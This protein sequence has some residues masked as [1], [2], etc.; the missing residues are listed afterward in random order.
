MKYLLDTNTRTRYLRDPNSRVRREL[1]TRPVADIFL[2]SVVLAELYRG[3]HKS[4]N[5]TANRATVDA[6]VAPY[7]SLS[8][9]D[10]AA[11]RQAEVRVSLERLGLMIGPYDSMIAA[12]GLV[13]GLTVVT[14]NTAEFG[15]VP[16]LVIEDWEI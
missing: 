9:D 4:A 8:F 3:A 13:H 10:P 1:A 16:G 14:H 12:V 2:C 7:V 6:F 5:P 15:R 11:D